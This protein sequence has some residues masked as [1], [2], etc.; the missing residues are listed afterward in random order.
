MGD[1][2]QLQMDKIFMHQTNVFDKLP[3]PVEKEDIAEC[4]ANFKT[5][6]ELMG[7]FDDDIGKLVIQSCSACGYTNFQSQTFTQSTK[8]ESREYNWKIKEPITKYQMLKY[9]DKELRD[10]KLNCQYANFYQHNG[11]KYHL[12]AHLVQNDKIDLCPKC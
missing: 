1:I 7:S 10:S 11:T 5:N 4:M 3:D 6:S 9:S 8:Y 12:I 2:K